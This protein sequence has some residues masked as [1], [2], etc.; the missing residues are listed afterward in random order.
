MSIFL[1]R[2]TNDDSDA[3]A[4]SRMFGKSVV[5]CFYKVN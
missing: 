2:D 4:S 3:P 1:S 5:T